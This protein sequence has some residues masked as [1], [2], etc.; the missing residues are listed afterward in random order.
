[1]SQSR[2]ANLVA[3]IVL[4]IAHPL[5]SRG[6]AAVI[7]ASLLAAAA[8]LGDEPRPPQST[9]A[10]VAADKFV[11]REGLSEYCGGG[12]PVVS[13]LPVEYDAK[14][15]AEIVDSAKTLGDAHRGVDVFCST[16][17]GCLSCHRVDKFGGAVGPPLTDI[18]R[19]AKPEEIVESVLWPKRQVKPEYSSWRIT[20]DDGRSLQ[21]Y[22]RGE[23]PD[24]IQ[25]FDPTTEKMRRIAKA[26]IADQREIGTLMPDGAAAAMSPA[27]RSDL[28]RFLMELGHT[29]G[30]EAEVRPETMPA[31]F[32]YEP[33]PL[34]PED[35]PLWQEHVN[36]DRVYDFYRKEA[37][38]FRGQ[39][40]RPRLLP[41]FPELDGG[42]YGHWGNQNEET[43]K[44]G[45]WSQTDLGTVLSGVFHGPHGDVPKGVCVRLG[46]HGELAAC[47]NPETLSYEALWR[48]G[49][50]KLSAVRHGFVDGLHPD[51]EL[52]P[53]P[54]GKRPDKPFVYH[55]FYRSGLRVVFTYRIGDVELLDAPWAKDGKFE[56]IVAPVADHPLRA[57]LHGG[58][59]QWPQ[60]LKTAAQLGAGRPYAV[61][62]IRPPFDNPWK[63]PMFFGDHDFLSDGSA[64]LCTMEGD[65][66]RVT[67]LDAELKDVRWRRFA[68]GLH[69]ALGLVVAEGQVYVLGRD[70]ITCLHDL[71]GDGEADLY[72]CI[73]NK[74]ITSSAGHDFICGLARDSQGRFYTASGNQGL[75]RISADGQK[76]DVLATGFR[77][78]DG[79]A[80]CPDGAVT[81]PCSE[82][83][84]TPA[85]MICLVKPDPP[86]A[87]APYFGYG[88]P[89]D[90]KL[91]AL[92]FA[93]LPRG[94]DNSSGGQVSVP[95]DR[96][97][98]LKG[99][100]IHFSFGQGSH[101][102]VLRDEVA[103]QPQGAIVPLV[104]DFRSGVHR[105]RFNPRDGQLYVSGLN[106]W[107]TY[108]PDDGCFQRVRYTGDPVQL[109]RSFH[110]HENGVLVSFTQPVDAKA[111]ANL[112]N[113]FAQV[114]NYRYTPGYGSP[115]FA[116]CHPGAVGHESL[117]I[118]GVHRIDATTIFVE[119][120]ALQPVN[121][122]HLL[123]QVDEG[124]PQELV[125]TVHRLDKPFTQFPGY[126]PT[127]KV[128]GAH[129][130]AV[131]LTLLR[132]ASPNPW[133]KILP[134]AAPL[135]LS[136]GNNLT[137][138]TRTLRAKAGEN[139]KLT[140][141]NPD[142]VPHN[143]VLVKKGALA[144]IGDLTNKLVAD[145]EAVFRQYVPKSD[146]VICY[147]DIVPS[148]Q[149]S[150][151]SFRAP[152]E[153]GRYPYLC[154]FPGHW[155]VMNGELVVE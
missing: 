153:K 129:P 20:L 42:K 51:G 60:E 135:D 6:T 27:Q 26:E 142:V 11:V 125:I 145:P 73:S 18:G 77:N 93:Y 64:L 13:N 94:L 83:D 28:A 31:E 29:T 84:W 46:Q 155:M 9:A 50:L 53:R 16:K 14:L 122:L 113:H 131:D 48:G 127:I 85:S 63:A 35:W 124:R 134:A 70:Q 39:L 34:I 67:G 103:G 72:E 114:W 95:D 99:Q 90:G 112:S 86:A 47:F 56:R 57:I 98:P 108:T 32:S 115:E 96:W 55:G 132:K 12:A 87:V 104:G 71:N 75:L 37:L 144:S 2:I 133:R 130:L 19:R 80:L 117:R 74:M 123:L 52:L 49:F 102:L 109:P 152:Q 22:K 100:M 62:T 139:V 147:T 36:R 79:V 7:F 149:Q 140:F 89:R 40:S 110:V 69:Q 58:A 137:F 17:F 76:V 111:I 106:G 41:A 107:G 154:T 141:H 24:A 43:W 151:I 118:A 82:G 25:L 136:A 4:A 92:P 66:W 10:P 21:G 105:G 148:G 119:L 23:T 91:P 33:G 15:V 101:F 120:P 45:R 143:W 121:Q 126:E 138:S 150:T 88:G 44:D 146:D 97:G 81:L 65:V 128:I 8:L 68:S 5:V 30:L 3:R 116:P 38:F 61:D 59:A 54:E 1:M 78:P